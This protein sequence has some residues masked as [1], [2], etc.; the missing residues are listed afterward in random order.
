MKKI[1][2]YYIYL[3][4]I[5]SFLIFLIGYMN[6]VYSYVIFIIVS[7][8]LI[9]S[10]YL[11]NFFRYRYHINSVIAKAAIFN[12]ILFIMYMILI[13][14][15]SNLSP[16]SKIILMQISLLSTILYVF[17]DFLFNYL[18]FNKNYNIKF[19]KNKIYLKYKFPK[20]YNLIFFLSMMIYVIHAIYN[21]FILYGNK[22][23]IAYSVFIFIEQV[24]Y[25]YLIVNLFFIILK[26]YKYLRFVSPLL[27]S[28]ISLSMSI[29][30]IFLL[31]EIGAVFLGG[32]NEIAVKE[33]VFINIIVVVLFSIMFYIYDMFLFFKKSNRF[34]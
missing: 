28:F 7:V 21:S 2:D 14:S 32:F 11:I 17:Y 10:A 19:F 22:F 31:M 12:F 24:F 4:I 20:R 13:Y 30:S 27:I 18:K 25:L 3:F 16:S 34:L 5:N 26:R 33:I 15:D 8:F 6:S 23:S 9:F 1:K 29:F